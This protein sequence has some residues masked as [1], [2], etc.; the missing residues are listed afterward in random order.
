MSNKIIKQKTIGEV[1]NMFSDSGTGFDANYILRKAEE[2]KGEIGVAKEYS[3]DSYT[4][5]ALTIFELDKG[6][7]LNSSIPDRFRI[8]ALEFSR[9]LQK[10]YYCI[11][12]SEKSLGNI[13]S[14]N[15]VRVLEIQNRINS[16]LNIGSI[17]DMG[18]RYLAIL[19]K[20]LDRAERHYLGSLQ[21]LRE[22][23]SPSFEVNIKT[24]TAVVG[25]NQAVQVK[26]A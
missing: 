1:K 17:T 4:Y 15:Y 23:H 14:L 12:P 22:L 6:I 16:Y 9:N 8:F 2:E 26:N 19:S 13:T 3:P 10:E 20:E 24:N 11:T 5:K 18:V 25:Q 21:A 7:L